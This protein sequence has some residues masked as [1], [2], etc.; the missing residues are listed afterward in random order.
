MSKKVL[1]LS[2]IA[3]IILL[4]TIFYPELCCNCMKPATIDSVEKPIVTTSDNTIK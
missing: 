2:G 3:I 4:G 1:Y